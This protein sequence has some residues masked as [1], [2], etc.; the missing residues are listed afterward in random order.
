MGRS[1][2]P[3]V[4]RLEHEETFWVD[5]FLV[6]FGQVVRAE[7]S[8]GVKPE[9]TRVR[10]QG[11]LK[12]IIMDSFLQSSFIITNWYNNRLVT[13][14]LLYGARGQMVTALGP[15]IKGPGDWFLI[16]CESLGQALNPHCLPP[17][18]SYGYQVEQ[19][20]VLC[21]WLQLQKM[22][23]SER[24]KLCK[25]ELQYLGVINVNSTEPMGISVL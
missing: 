21:E 3:M 24:C 8:R 23:Y 13:K 20:F 2:Y 12:I 25:R 6:H 9:Y 5:G 4:G 17:P 18:S 14:I 10:F 11:I 19:K 7:A 1:K 15:L 22:L 16:M